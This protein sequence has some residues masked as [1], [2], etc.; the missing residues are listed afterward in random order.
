MKKILVIKNGVATGGTTTSFLAFLDSMIKQ[1]E[2]IVEAWIGNTPQDKIQE[3]IP[4]EITC[5]KNS[6]LE[7]A[8]KVETGFKKIL[9][10]I[11]NRQLCL[12]LQYHLFDM[13][14]KGKNQLI[15]LF[16]KMDIRRAKS[17][18]NIDLMEY[19]AVLTWEEFYPCYLLA[20][21]IQAKKKI[22]WIHPHYQ[23]CGF[24]KKYDYPYFRKLDAIVTV[25][26]N[27]QAS[28][29]NIFPEISEKIYAVENAILTNAILKK[30][31]EPQSEIIHWEGI[32]IVTVARLQNVSKALDRA[33]RIAANLK[34]EG[35]LFKWY[36]IGD[37]EDRE[38]LIEMIALYGLEKEIILLGQQNNPYKYVKAADLFVL[39]SYY[40]GRPMVVDEAMI[41][42][43]PVF[44]SNY[45]AAS[46]QVPSKYGII[47]DNNEVD[48]FKG[49]RSIINDL[50]LLDSY[51]NNLK[52][53]NLDVYN[54]TNRYMELIKGV[55]D[56][57][58][59]ID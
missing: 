46:E 49:L 4:K 24:L 28:M 17:Q 19:D 31:M 54:A 59:A 3:V 16:Q 56:N 25:S 40:E 18:K 9:T 34:N 12:T 58:C 38:M 47:V 26:K 2:I 29:Q 50:N 41:I 23:Q 11:K 52:G 5:I 7:R 10:L 14:R 42:G 33:I 57:D 6:D 15:P 45:S 35:L 21:K 37:G 13:K 43:T 22:A 8:F 27:C 53:L 32:N 20:E 55:I 30:C 1:K 39:Q 44:V 48:I 51:K 36:F